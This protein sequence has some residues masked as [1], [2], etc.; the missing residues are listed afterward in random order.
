MRVSNHTC[1]NN[2]MCLRYIPFIY[3]SHVYHIINLCKY[4]VI[5]SI[6]VSRHVSC[7][8][9]IS[10]YTYLQIKS[11]NITMYLHKHLSLNKNAY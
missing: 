2:H 8:F 11:E 5:N 7:T 4:I 9:L 1:L 3:F 6:M 10:V